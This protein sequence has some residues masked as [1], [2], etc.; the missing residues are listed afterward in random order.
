M[1]IVVLFLS[2]WPTKRLLEFEIHVALKKKWI[3][4]NKSTERYVANGVIRT[5]DPV[6]LKFILFIWI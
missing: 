2:K 5:F 4:V 1:T 6:K 3:S